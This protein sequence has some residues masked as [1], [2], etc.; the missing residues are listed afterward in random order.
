MAT[1]ALS[2][3]PR[4]ITS[5]YARGIIKLKPCCCFVNSSGG[6]MLTLFVDTMLRAGV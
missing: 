2:L 4:T 3:A 6:R 1:P 5:R